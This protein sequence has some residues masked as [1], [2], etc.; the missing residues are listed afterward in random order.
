MTSKCIVGLL[1]SEENQDLDYCISHANESGYQFIVTPITKPSFRRVLNEDDSMSPQEHDMWKEQ[2]VFDRQDL[3]IRSATWS[4]NII[5]L[6]SNWI[7]LD[8]MHQDIRLCSEI[9]FK[10]ETQW[11]THIGLPGVLLHGLPKNGLY[12]TARVVGSSISS[13]GNTK[14]MVRVPVTD[15]RFPNTNMSW[16][17]WNEFRTLIDYNPMV[18]IALELT[19]QLPH[20]ELWLKMWL[21]EPILLVIVPAEI[22]VTNKK[23]YPVLTKPIQHFLKMLLHKMDVDVIV[24]KPKVNLHPASSYSAYIYY[25]KRNLPE[26]DQIE[27]HA[28][29]LFDIVQVPSQP[30]GHHD[31]DQAYQVLEI[32]I[33]KYQLYEQAIHQALLDYPD[34][35]LI[36]IVIVGA[37]RGP[38]VN[39]CLNASKL[40]GRPIRVYAIEKNPQVY[41]TLQKQKET[42]WKGSNVE[43][44]LSDIREWNMS[45]KCDILVS[46]L[47]G[48]FGD[49]QLSPECLECAKDL[50][51]SN[52]ICIPTSYSAYVSPLASSHLYNMTKAPSQNETTS[53]V[54]LRKACELAESQQLWTFIH[55]DDKA[56]CHSRYGQVEFKVS[57]DAVMHGFAGYFDCTLY[58]NITLSTRPETRTP[59]LFGCFVF[60]FPL[61]RPMQLSCGDSIIASFWR[62]VDTKTAYR[63]WYEWTVSIVKADDHEES[64][65][66][67]NIGGRSFSVVHH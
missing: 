57:Q 60:Y 45:E 3:V 31:N 6:M 17:R 59:N 18:C 54:M 11:A 44:V 30:M 10:Q 47:L 27:R 40:T 28:P 65:P 32:D 20:D 63:T 34:Q 46:E 61:K 64:L 33:A 9:A 66:I 41:V 21:A 42:M 15:K 26:L 5:G 52:G 23:G 12:N 7:H 4:S 49:N 37:G 8:S 55:P 14:L 29:A 1:V 56:S 25:L 22:F 67:H 43:I 50:L 36:T 62:M 2:P 19:P 48:A 39:C 13:M 24:T 58:K 16:Q 38:L 35:E 53:I 51:R